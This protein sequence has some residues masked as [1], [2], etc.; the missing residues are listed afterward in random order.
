MTDT[1]TDSACCT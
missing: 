1:D